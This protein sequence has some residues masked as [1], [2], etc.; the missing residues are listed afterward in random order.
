MITLN[1][2]DDSHNDRN[3]FSPLR[4]LD[5]SQAFVIGSV[6]WSEE[7]KEE[8]ADSSLRYLERRDSRLLPV[9]NRTFA[10]AER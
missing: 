7:K 1:E 10:K 3:N 5:R 9:L 2:S 8:K 6:G 4:A